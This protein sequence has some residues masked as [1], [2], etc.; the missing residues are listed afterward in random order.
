MQAYSRKKFSLR[1]RLRSFRY[2][3]RGIEMAVRTQHNFRIHII[4]FILVIAAGFLLGISPR[5][6]CIILIVSAWVL[7]LEII[8]TAMELTVDIISPEFREKAGMI[9]DLSAAA[10]LVAAL[11]AAST[12]VIIFGKYILQLLN[13]SQ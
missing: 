5:E 3:F 4:A 10:V 12:G 8:N 11:A 13:I 1:E 6:W 9:K 2:A 7:S